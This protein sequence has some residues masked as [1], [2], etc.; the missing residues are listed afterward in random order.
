M[1]FCSKCGTQLVDEAVVCTACGCAVQGGT[2]LNQPLTA[3]PVQAPSVPKADKK[4]AKNFIPIFNFVALLGIAASVFFVFMA[5][6]EMHAS[7][8]GSAEIVRYYSSYD[9]DLNLYANVWADYDYMFNAFLAAIIAAPFPIVSLIF[10]I[11]EK[12]KLEKIFSA[13]FKIVVCTLLIVL[14]ALYI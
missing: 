4:F 11:K 3:E 5:L 10:T 6:A 12:S 7:A 1:K 2:A 9:L 14:T 8:H 13:I